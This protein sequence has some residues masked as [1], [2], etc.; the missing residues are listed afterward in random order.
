[1]SMETKI[2]PTISVRED[3]DRLADV[4]CDV[5]EPVPLIDSYTDPDSKHL[6]TYGECVTTLICGVK[7]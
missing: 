3:Y 5:A 1:M 7:K 4:G 6:D 2:K